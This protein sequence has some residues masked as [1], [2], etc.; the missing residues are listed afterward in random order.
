M[1]AK[2][3]KNTAPRIRWIRR[4]AVPP[5]TIR[6]NLRGY[7]ASGFRLFQMICLSKCTNRFSCILQDLLLFHQLVVIYWRAGC[8]DGAVGWRFEYISSVELLS[9]RLSVTNT[10]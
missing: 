7:T 6:K 9:G 10:N 8:W 2:A 5:R 4:A 1:T 3:Q